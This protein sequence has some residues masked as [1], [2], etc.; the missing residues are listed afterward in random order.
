MPFCYAPWTNI[1]IDPQGIM[2]PC[3]K[4]QRAVDD[5]IFNVQTH[6]LDQYSRS[7][8]LT[9]LKQ[10]F[11]QDTWPD[12]CVRCRVEEQSSI[13]SKRQLDQERWPTHYAQYQLDS[14]QWLTASIAFGNT[15]NLKCITCSSDTSSRWRKE[16]H[17]IYGQDFRPVKFY[18]NNFVE[19]FVSQAP[20]IIHLDVP[21]GEPFLSGL[22]EQ[23]KLLT[24]YID[25]GQAKNISLHYTTNATV[26]PDRDWWDKWNHFREIEIQLSIDGVG[27]RQEY[28]RYPANWEVIKDNVLKYLQHGSSNLKLSVSHTV[29]AYNIF[30]LDEFFTWCHN[31]GLPKPWLGRVYLPEHM[32]PGVWPGSAHVVD[33]LLTSKHKD[34]RTWAEMINNTNDHEHFDEFCR[35]LHQHDQYR[36]LNFADVFPEMADFIN[37]C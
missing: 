25:S 33:H 4:Y 36:G 34:V 8:F 7:A 5:P 26:F 16:F 12:G 14:D 22:A 20:G 10:K 37:D 32:R 2:M 27:P 19:S 6:S 23:K 11:T 13:K 31:I 3:C 15:C 17:E 35:R 18:R 21:G 24:H 9:D 30:Y 28:I 29:S 1:D